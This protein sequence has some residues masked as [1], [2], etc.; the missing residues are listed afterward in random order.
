[1]SNVGFL[2][3]AGASYPFGIP[4]M[5][6]F[7]SNF[8][9]YVRNKRSHCHGLMIKLESEAADYMD[10]ET[11]ISQLDKIRGIRDG[12][13]ALGRK[14]DGALAA[15]LDVAEELRGYLDAYLIEVCEQFDR[16]KVKNTL[17]PFVQYCYDSNTH[18]FSTNY[19]RLIETAADG[20]G[21]ACSDG[22]EQQSG[23]PE[24][25]W[26]GDVEASQGIRLV[27]LHGSVNWYK[28]EGSG[29]IFRLERGYSLPSHEY[30]LTH[31]ER[32]L[33]PLMII[34]TLEK[35][36]LQIPYA[37]LLTTFSDALLSMDLL[38]VIGNSM[39][40]EH[41]RNT[42]AA[43]LR[44][45]YV[46][47]VNPQADGQVSLFGDGEKVQAMPIGMEDFIR[48]GIPKLR[49]MSSEGLR[50]SVW[51]NS[52]DDVRA[53][54]QEVLSGVDSVDGMSIEDRQ[55]LERLRSGSSSER[56]EV[57]NGIG[58]EAHK[59][60]ILQLRNIAKEGSTESEQIGAVDA[61]AE[62]GDMGSI[63][64]LLEVVDE[65]PTLAVKAEAILA[66][67]QILRQN[68][69]DDSP[70]VQRFASRNQLERSLMSATVKVLH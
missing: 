10:L 8:V 26:I 18:I 66:L 28:E 70:Y 42:I 53:F 2:L 1:M 19:D 20:L 23:R 59:E 65:S 49:Q 35:T 54:V 14:D 39:R 12:L 37:T 16:N 13:S 4:M 58:G 21:V 31:G 64:L 40:D 51:G 30:R 56:I 45:L 47:L 46:V 43:R 62:V 68:G 7:Y 69:V 33:R 24:A 32:A 50:S 48:I 41:I 17:T 15:E 38:I 60:V 61:L 52:G 5:R 22:F 44:G 9:N 3:G 67:K 34:P 11:L 25:A 63:D 6:E 57:M 55:V 36:V 29:T 27:K